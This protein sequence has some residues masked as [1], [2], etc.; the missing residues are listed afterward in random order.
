M[1]RIKTK[2][3][4]RVARKLF[5]FHKEEFKADFDY[6]KLRVSELSQ[7]HSLKLRNSIAGLITKL[8]KLDKK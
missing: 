6:N 5:F 7:I 3:I 4:K 1:G 8:V 2:L